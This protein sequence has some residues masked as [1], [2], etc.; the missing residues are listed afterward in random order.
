M[1]LPPWLLAFTWWW[2]DWANAKTEERITFAGEGLLS[3]RFLGSGIQEIAVPRDLVSPHRL[4]GGLAWQPE[5]W[6]EV[7]AGVWWAPSY[8]PT[9]SW[10]FLADGSDRLSLSAGLGLLDLFDGRLEV[11]TH[12]QW[13]RITERHIG[14]GESAVLGGSRELPPPGSPSAAVANDGDSVVLDGDV[15]NWGLTAELRL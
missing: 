1:G 12:L 5:P 2:E 14:V 13:T 10:D 7:L 3:N 11:V 4:R 6:L 8:A 9:A 15:F